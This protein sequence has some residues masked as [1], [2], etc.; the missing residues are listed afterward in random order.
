VEKGSGSGDDP[1]SALR[2]TWGGKLMCGRE[3][4]HDEHDEAG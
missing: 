3:G 2:N 4:Y 1:A